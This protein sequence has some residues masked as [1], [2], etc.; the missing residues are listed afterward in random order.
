M[1]TRNVG[2]G[3][4]KDECLSK[5]IPFGERS[6]RRAMKD[7]I[8]HYHTERITK[9][10]ITYCFSVRLQKRAATSQCDVAIGWVGFCGTIIETQREF[11]NARS[12]CG[13]IELTTTVNS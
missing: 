12:A 8:A 5:I 11:V 13:L 3:P 10:R 1:P 2:C 4:V 6:L 9:V 7:Y